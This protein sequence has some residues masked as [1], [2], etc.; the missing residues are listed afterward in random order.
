MGKGQNCILVNF[1]EGPQSN[2][3]GKSIFSILLLLALQLMSLAK[4]PIIPNKG[5][6]DPHIRIMEGKGDFYIVFGVW[7]YFNAKLNNDMIS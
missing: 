6:N 1:V 3:M 7:D 4:N 2:K 5:V